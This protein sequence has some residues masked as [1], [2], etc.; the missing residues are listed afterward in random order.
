MGN[1]A[2]DRRR[3]MIQFGETVRQVN[4]AVLNPIMEPLVPTELEPVVAMVANARA[5]Y[6]QALLSLA[7]ESDGETAPADVSELRLARERYEE[8]LAAT[9]ALETMIERGYLDVNGAAAGAQ[10]ERVN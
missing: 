6:L 2:K 8:L 5:E 3:L 7:A 9:S 10:A 1:A 4:R